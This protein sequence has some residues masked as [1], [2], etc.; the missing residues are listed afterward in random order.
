MNTKKV[1]SL[2]EAAHCLYA[3]PMDIIGKGYF[4]GNLKNINNINLY[5]IKEP[6]ETLDIDEEWQFKSF[7]SIY[8]NIKK[9][10]F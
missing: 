7:E 5:V 2:F 8:M 4:M 3:S 9:K 10:L 6:I 1:D